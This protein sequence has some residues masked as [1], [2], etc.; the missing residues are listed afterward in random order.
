VRRGD[1]AD[2]EWIA[3]GKIQVGDQV[4]SLAGPWRR[5][6]SITPVAGTETVYN[7]TVDKDHDYFVGETG[8]LVHNASG[9]N[10]DPNAYAEL[11]ELYDG[12]GNF[13]K[14]GISFDAS[15]L[16]TGPTLDGY[17]GSPGPNVVD[18]GTRRNM[19]SQEREL[20]KRFPGPLNCERGAGSNSMW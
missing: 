2:G 18:S 5:V 15:T 14:W 19:L 4:E 20:K 12:F 13:L 17:G 9:C 7:F 6:V 8:F 10:C 11:Y 3:A 16:Y 1:R